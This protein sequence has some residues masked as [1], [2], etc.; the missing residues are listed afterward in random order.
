MKKP[1]KKVA[2]YLIVRGACPA[3]GED[4]SYRAAQYTKRPKLKHLRQAFMPDYQAYDGC[5]GR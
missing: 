5:E 3:C 1:K 4:Q 2:W